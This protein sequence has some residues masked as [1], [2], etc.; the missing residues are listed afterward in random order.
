[1]VTTTTVLGY[2]THSCRTMIDLS[3]KSNACTI[4]SCDGASKYVRVLIASD[5]GTRHTMNH[6]DSSLG[7]NSCSSRHSDRRTSLAIFLHRE[8]FSCEWNSYILNRSLILYI[9][10]YEFR[11]KTCCRNPDTQALS[12]S[13]CSSDILK[14]S[15]S[16]I[17]DNET[18]FVFLT[19]FQIKYAAITRGISLPRC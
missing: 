14:A 18:I 5:I 7:A 1:M 3:A 16:G 12:T 11:A 10:L 17:S 15:R 8:F 6:R 13:W 2:R 4:S 9:S 19:N